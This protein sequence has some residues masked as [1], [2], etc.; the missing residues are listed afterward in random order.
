MLLILNHT[1]SKAFDVGGSIPIQV[2]TGSIP[3]ISPLLQFQGY[4]PIYYKVDDSHFP[5]DS[6][7]KH[8]CWVSI[9]EHVGHATTFK[10]LTDNTKK[11]IYRLNIHSACDPKSH[12]LHEDFLNEDARLKPII[13]SCHDS[14]DHREGSPSPIVNLNDLIGHMFLMPQQEDG[15]WF[16]ACMIIKA[17]EDHEIKLVSDP[18]H[19]KF[20]CSVNDDHK[21]IV[22]CNHDLM[23]SLESTEDGKSNVWNFRCITAPQGLLKPHDQDYN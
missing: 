12:N 20:L 8:S 11:I 7:E 17:I 15:Q 19:I 23:N 1:A 22:S 9:T 2:L 14:L 6:C 10:K 16:C 13:K 3:N 4:E 18:E 5:L 21:E